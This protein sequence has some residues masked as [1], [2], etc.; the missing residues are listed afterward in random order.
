LLVTARKDEN[1]N[2]LAMAH[3][4]LANLY[5]EQFHRPEYAKLHYWKVLELDSQNSQAT[6]IRYWLR[7]N[8]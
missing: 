1:S 8:P 2:H 3:L 5:S 7:D 6:A 4:T